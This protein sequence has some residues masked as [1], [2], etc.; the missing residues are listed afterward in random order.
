MD[1]YKLSSLYHIACS[2]MHDIIDDLYEA[3]HDEFGQPLETR[4]GIEEA[5][6][7]V[8]V[9]LYQELDLIKSAVDEHEPYPEA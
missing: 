4:E 6:Q 9:S 8:K 1:T 7:G 2:R 3:V 5:M